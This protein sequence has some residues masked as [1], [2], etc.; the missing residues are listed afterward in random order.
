MIGNA[1]ISTSKIHRRSHFLLFSVFYSKNVLMI[2]VLLS[3]RELL[4]LILA[5]LPETRHN[6]PVACSAYVFYFFDKA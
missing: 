3:L 5:S 4:V 1:S 6:F 2:K